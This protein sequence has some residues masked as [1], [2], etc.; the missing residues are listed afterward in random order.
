VPAD[1]APGVSNR[2]PTPISGAKRPKFTVMPPVAAVAPLLGAGVGAGA[3]AVVAVA[4]IVVAAGRTSVGSQSA[5]A[6]AG[7]Q[8]GAPALGTCALAAAAAAVAR[9]MVGSGTGPCRAGVPKLMDPARLTEPAAVEG[10]A[11][12]AGASAAVPSAADGS[13]LTAPSMPAGA[14][15]LPMLTEQPAPLAVVAAT[16]AAEAGVPGGAT[17]LP[18]LIELPAPLAVAVADEPRRGEQCRLAAGAG[19]GKPSSAGAAASAGVPASAEGTAAA[20]SAAAL[21]RRGKCGSLRAAEGGTGGAPLAWGLRG[22]VRRE[23]DRGGSGA[24]AAAGASAGSGARA[25]DGA[26]VLSKEGGTGGA[27][28]RARGPRASTSVWQDGVGGYVVGTGVRPARRR[29]RRLQ[30]ARRSSRARSGVQLTADQPACLLPQT[31]VAADL[32]H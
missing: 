28:P 16:V 12:G 22:G 6:A 26:G 23:G 25:P 7:P 29:G 30:A 19:A 18:K 24:A 32:E 15:A 27:L 4:V 13:A 31:T 3:A 21:A 11:P 10:E 8:T 17:A 1:G 2:L 5:A 9:H 14:M 20:A